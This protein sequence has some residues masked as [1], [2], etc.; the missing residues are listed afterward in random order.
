VLG[1][2]G[3]GY[4]AWLTAAVMIVLAAS[5]LSYRCI[6][7]P[8]RNMLRNRIVLRPRRGA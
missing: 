7:V 5:A 1:I 3:W 8:A 6:E 4:A 2:G